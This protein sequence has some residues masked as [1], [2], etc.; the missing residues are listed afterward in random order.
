[1]KAATGIIHAIALVFDHARAAADGAFSVV[2]LIAVEVLAAHVFT[3]YLI[4]AWISAAASSARF[5]ADISSCA[6]T[7]P[8]P[9][10]VSHQ[11]GSCP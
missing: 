2:D 4:G 1:M 8:L 10:Q 5:I 11:S 6:G 3:D 9:P 7:N